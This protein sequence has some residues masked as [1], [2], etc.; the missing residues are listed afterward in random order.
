MVGTRKS[1]KNKGADD[2]ESEE[3]PSKQAPADPPKTRAKRKAGATTKEPVTKK[4]KSTEGMCSI[5]VS[6]VEN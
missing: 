2:E 4:H 6:G 1:A 5:C 3:V